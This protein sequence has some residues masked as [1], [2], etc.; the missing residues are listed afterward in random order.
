[1]PIRQTFA[2]RNKRF[3]VLFSLCLL[4]GFGAAASAQQRRGRGGRTP[5]QPQR[6]PVDT[7]ILP[8]SKIYPPIPRDIDT[9]C[10]GFIEYEPAQP[11]IQVVGGEQEQEQ[12]SYSD[13]DYV[14]INAA[15]SQGLTV[16]QEFS[17]VRPRGRFHT[18]LTSKRGVLGVYTQQVGRLRITE[19]K[20]DVSIARV[21]QSCDQ[22]LLGDTL[23]ATPQPLAT[24]ALGRISTADRS[25]VSTLDRFTDANG[26]PQGRI[27]LARDGRELLSRNQVVFIDLGSEDNVKDGDVLTIF[28]PVEKGGVVHVKNEEITQNTHA[29]FESDEFK[30][31]KFSNKAQRSR[32]PNGTGL[33]DAEPITSH[34]IKNKRTAMP[35]KVV[36]ELVVINVEQRTATAIITTVAQEIHTGDYVEVK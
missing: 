17:V 19:L 27:V 14:Y 16:G 31:G 4:L 35:R 18:K 32:V 22:I 7:V 10:A 26:K 3:A 9:Q 34:M 20:Q 30:G 23:R 25:M 13:G 36:G 24:A 15:A 5:T 33:S 2:L 8:P 11:A 29:G 21:T 12:N 28:R 1:V 6:I